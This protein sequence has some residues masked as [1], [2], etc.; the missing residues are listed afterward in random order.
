MDKFR[1]AA[2][3]AGVQANAFAQQTGRAINEQAA[4]ARAG[5][6]LPKECDRAAKILQAFLADPEH[7][8]SA[9]N[10]IP[11]AVLQQAKGLAVFSVIKAGF[12]WSGKIVAVSLSLG[13]PMEAVGPFMHWYWCCWI[14]TADWC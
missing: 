11:K 13:C 14:W 2:Q 1:N 5:F 8:D 3:K 4:T 6:A 10:S 12:V 7:P 9:L